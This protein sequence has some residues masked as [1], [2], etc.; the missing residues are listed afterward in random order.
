[1]SKQKS[2][3][4]DP[5]VIGLLLSE[6]ERDRLI[7]ERVAEEYRRMVALSEAMGIHD[8]PPNWYEVALALAKRHVPELKE[9]KRISPPIKWTMFERT[10]LGG[11]MMRLITRE[12]MTRE[13]AAK[14]LAE[15]EPWTSFLSKKDGTYQHDPGAALIKYY[16]EREAKLG[17]DIYQVL[18]ADGRLGEW[19]QHLKKISRNK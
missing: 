12:G 7:K 4:L 16:R 5:L 9:N 18:E 2:C 11:E 10:M 1:M 8:A 17:W 19:T 14:Q 15:E 13:E 3:G 6:K